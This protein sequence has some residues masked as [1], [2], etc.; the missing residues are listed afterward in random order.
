MDVFRVFL[1]TA[2]YFKDKDFKTINLCFRGKVR[3]ILKGVDF[4]VM[5]NDFGSQNPVYTLRT[6]PEKL[7]LPNGSNAYQSHRGGLLY[8]MKVQMEDLSDMNGI[9]YLNELLSE[10]KADKDA[11][12]PKK[13]APDEKV[14]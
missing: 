10:K 6:F 3:F 5:G 7:L 4:K 9:W 11:L 8:L 13:F 2:E 1:H 14:F 12:R